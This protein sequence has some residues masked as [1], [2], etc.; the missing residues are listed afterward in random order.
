MVGECA[1]Q[2]KGTGEGAWLVCWELEKLPKGV[3]GTGVDGFKLV[4]QRNGEQG[5]QVWGRV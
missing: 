1:K 3:P 4:K 5:F 2:N